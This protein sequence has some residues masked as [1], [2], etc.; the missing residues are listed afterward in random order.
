[1]NLRG[2]ARQSG[3]G[4][5]LRFCSAGAELCTEA[6]TSLLQRR[7]ASITNRR[8]AVGCSSDRCASTRSLSGEAGT[9]RNPINSGRSVLRC[10]AS[11]CVRAIDSALTR[12]CHRSP[13]PLRVD[14]ISSVLVSGSPHREFSQSSERYAPISPATR[15]EWRQHPNGP[16]R[17]ST[18]PRSHIHHQFALFCLPAPA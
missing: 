9:S 16:M 11:W 1:M 4:C 5:T 14:P 10:L 6:S 13:S 12:N 3:A 2:S 8:V 15:T 7:A 17:A 18:F